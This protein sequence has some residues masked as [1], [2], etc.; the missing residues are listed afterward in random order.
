MMKRNRCRASERDNFSGGHGWGKVVSPLEDQ[1]ED[2]QN[3]S[4]VCDGWMSS[5][6]Y[7]VPHTQR[8]SI[9]RVDH[10]DHETVREERTQAFGENLLIWFDLT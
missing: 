2:D 4:E 6:N 7:R 3:G 8:G 10:A 9:L 5:E 1:L